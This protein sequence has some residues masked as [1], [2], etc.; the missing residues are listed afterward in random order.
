MSESSTSK[1]L[2][3]GTTGDYKP[4]TWR[5]QTT[6]TF[7]G[8]D[9]D[10]VTAFATTEGMTLVFVP[11][12]WA[13]MLDDLVEG[14]FEMA[15]GGISK[16]DAREE[17]AL[18]SDPIEATGKVALVRCGEERHYRTLAEV[19]RAGVRVIENRGGTN[20]RF[21]LE[22]ISHAEI[23]LV[24]DN[25]EPFE[26]LRTGKAGVMFTDL[27][28]AQF[29]EQQ[30]TGLCAVNADRPFTHVDTVFLFRK[31]EEGLRRAFNRWLA[32][33]QS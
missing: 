24:P 9:I 1:T 3:I 18:L 25:H 28:E 31:D 12:T 13:A 10:L 17:A 33:R 30:R 2:R 20:E 32:A 15:A 4:L 19:D 5:D 11:T 16:S 23:I 26:F 8:R 14:K 6:G 29:L 21:G 7:S 22:R 27:L